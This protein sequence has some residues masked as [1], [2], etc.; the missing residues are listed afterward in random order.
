MGSDVKAELKVTEYQSPSRF[1]FLAM[2]SSGVHTH[3][4]DIRPDNEGSRIV[5]TTTS[6][7]PLIIFIGFNVWGWRFVGKP[8]M[9]K[10]YQNL[11]AQV[12]TAR[13]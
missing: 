1:R 3:E 8:G 6:V 9:K 2:D 12:E 11:K 4:I 5:R 7:M 13:S 10:W